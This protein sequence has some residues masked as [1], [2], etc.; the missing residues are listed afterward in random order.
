[1]DSKAI[2]R[3]LLKIVSVAEH[4]NGGCIE[5]GPD[6]YLYLGMGDSAPNFDPQGHG[7]NLGLLYGKMLRI[8]VDRCDT[9]L[10]YGI[11][12]DNPFCRRPDV[13]PEIWAY[14]FREP[15]RFSFDRANSDLW[16]ADLGQE[17]GDEVAIV[18]RGE[19]HGWN[20]YEGFELFSSEHRRE[21]EV[22]VPPIFSNRRKFG[23]A[24]M[25]GCVYRGDKH[26]TFYGVYIFGDYQSKRIWGLTQ[27]NRSLKSIR[28]L[29]ISPQA[30]TSF[31]ADESGNIYVVGYQGMVYALDFAG[32]NFNEL[33]DDSPSHSAEASG[34]SQSATKKNDQ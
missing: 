6:G 10:P 4:H 20:V 14:G 33:A 18:R 15:W 16:V 1:M 11:P 5:F 3:R 19:N 8:D 22:Y 26:S 23:S 7:Q 2:P 29:A 31:A 13:R 24:V 9:G 17:R 28:Q 27:N 30:I 12:A 34:G 21:G 25:G 32:A